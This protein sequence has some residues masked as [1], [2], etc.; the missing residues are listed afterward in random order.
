ML[1]MMNL[2]RH[3]YWYLIELKQ[4][5]NKLRIATYDEFEKAFILVPN[6]QAPIISKILRANHAHIYV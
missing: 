1:S 5:L 4:T 6:K 3:L 2:K